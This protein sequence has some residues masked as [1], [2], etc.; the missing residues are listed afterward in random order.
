MVNPEVFEFQQPC[1][2]EMRAEHLWK[3]NHSKG[4]EEAV[5][6]KERFWASVQLPSQK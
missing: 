1:G 3:K 6:L 4:Q 5:S 2:A